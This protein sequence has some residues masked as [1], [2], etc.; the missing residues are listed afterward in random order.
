MSCEDIKNGRFNNVPIVI[1][2]SFYRT[3]LRRGKI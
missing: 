1:K 2:M 3:H